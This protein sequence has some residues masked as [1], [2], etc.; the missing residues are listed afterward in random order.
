M[1]HLTNGDSAANGLRAGVPGAV[2][3]WA[4]VLHEGPVP[5]LAPAAFADVRARYLSLR[6]YA[7]LEGARRAFARQ[8]AALDDVGR[9]D[10]TVL[11]FEHDLF[12]QLLLAQLLDRLVDTPRTGRLSLVCIDRFQ[13]VDRF[14]GLGQLSADQLASLLPARRE[15][16][17][18]DLAEGRQAWQA[19][20]APRP[21]QLVEAAASASVGLP[22]LAPALQRLLAEYPN[23]ET[24]LSGTETTIA[25]LVSERPAT[26]RELFAALT[27]VEPAPFLGDAPFFAAL[28]DLA[29]AR[30]PLL[31]A[32]NPPWLPGTGD[33]SGVLAAMGSTPV[34]LTE[35][36]HAV[37]NGRADAVDANGIDRWIGGVHLEGARAAWRWN[38]GQNRLQPTDQLGRSR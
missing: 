2:A 5:A 9:H 31:A 18:I 17:E 20:T 4:D 13:G 29:T 37:A 24:G 7:P 19:I 6:G 11:W 30:R 25:R 34:S 12:D 22:F 15:V 14:L 26:G 27:R 8:E 35:F 10:E 36:G 32:L 38:A 21:D 3:T 28:L 16:T 23:T 33:R 1:L